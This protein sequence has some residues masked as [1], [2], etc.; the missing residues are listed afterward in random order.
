MKYFVVVQSYTQWPVIRHSVGLFPF[1]FVAKKG[2]KFSFL[3]AT[4]RTFVAKN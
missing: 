4:F 3:S 1:F 2:N